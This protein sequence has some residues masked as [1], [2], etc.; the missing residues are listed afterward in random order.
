MGRC[1]WGLLGAAA[2]S[3][4]GFAA[5]PAK[6]CVVVAPVCTGAYAECHPNAAQRRANERRWSAEQTRL[7][8]RESQERLRAGEVDFSFELAELLVPN[9]RPVWIERS[10]CGPEG[11]IDYGEGEETFESMF[12]RVVQGTPLSAARHEEF[13]EF[14]H[15]D[16]ADMS[17]GPQCNAEFRRSF[18]E[19]LSRAL[20]PA[21][22][23][24]AWLFLAPR[25]RVQGDFF[26]IYHRLMSFERRARTPPVRWQLGDMWLREQV[27]RWLRRNAT[28]HL[29]AAAI[30][31]FW[32]ERASML[33]DDAQVCP[34]F[35]AQWQAER[36]SLV[37]RMIEWQ[38]S[39]RDPGPAS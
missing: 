26:R 10:D 29:L 5:A 22:R 7:L 36:L 14:L 20:G 32:A 11:E 27:E 9:L 25:Q 6:A 33:D 12:E 8:L 3:V 2:V 39:R 13:E 34:A 16:P 37:A 1:G 23:R 4:L 31:G 19:F 38:A 21:E 24:E 17:F 30:D 35:A 18:A 28:G 15:R